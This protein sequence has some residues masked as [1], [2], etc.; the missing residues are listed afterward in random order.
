MLFHRADFN[1][2]PGVRAGLFPALLS[3]GFGLCR[4]EV[5]SGKPHG[6]YHWEFPFS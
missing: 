1:P 5:T 2:E 6:L 3:V 4:R